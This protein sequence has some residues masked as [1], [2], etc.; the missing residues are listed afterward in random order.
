MLRLN[1]LKR[2]PGTGKNTKRR[3]RGTAS[4]QG[5]T[6]G[7]G[8]KGQKARKSGGTRP[9][10]EGGQ[11]PLYR[12]LPKIGFKNPG[13][14]E[15]AIM[16]MSDLERLDPSIKEVTLEALKEAGRVRSKAEKLAVLGNG[17]LTRA[18]TV[19]AHRV[20]ASAKEK[21]SKA[22]GSSEVLTVVSGLRK[23]QIE[24]RK[25]K[26]SRAKQA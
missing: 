21:I 2:Q 23:R 8:H 6:A 10:F 24:A 20:S 15:T 11:T 9:G 22:G 16:N 5:E 1:N 17:E 14:R 19:K 3:G 4:G 18:L 13:R 26:K 25:E 12:R 7:R